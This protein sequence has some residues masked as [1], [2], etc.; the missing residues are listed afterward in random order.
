MGTA[1]Q[2]VT[3]TEGRGEGPGRRSENMDGGMYVAV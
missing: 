1:P 2:R 3:A